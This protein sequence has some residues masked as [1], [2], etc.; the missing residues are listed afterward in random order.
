MKNEPILLVD[1]HHG[2]FCAQILAEQ[3]GHLMPSQ[4]KESIDICLVGPEHP[5]YLE[6]WQDLECIQ[7]TID[8]TPYTIEWN[9]GDI[10]AVPEGVSFFEN[11]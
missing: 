9:D 5:E 6:A 7:I 3:Y 1:N 10:W 4:L 8:S 11:Y 2:I